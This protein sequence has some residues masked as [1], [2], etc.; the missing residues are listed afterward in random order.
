M[1][2]SFSTP[3]TVD[4]CEPN[5]KHSKYVAEPFNTLSSIPLILLGAHQIYQAVS[6]KLG[7]RFIAMGISILFVGLGSFLFHLTLLFMG[8]LAD[9]FAMVCAGIC[10][11]IS[12]HFQDD[13]SIQ[14]R[15]FILS[16]GILYCLFF[17]ITYLLFKE[18]YLFFIASFVFLVATTFISAWRSVRIVPDALGGDL[19]CNL[20]Y[21]ILIASTMAALFW[22]PDSVWCEFTQPYQLHALWHMV[23]LIPPFLMFT[24]IASRLYAD[25]FRAKTGQAVNIA[26][27]KILSLQETAALV[28]VDD[29]DPCNIVDGHSASIGAV[30][31][32]ILIPR[33][34]WSLHGHVPL[35][36]FKG[37]FE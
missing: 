13:Q 35:F 9:E 3:S 24:I 21:C 26:T 23:G 6:L 34:D 19:L 28:L 11:F 36:A 10:Y 2:F 30:S 32:E 4:F 20:F 12:F 18:W 15:I 16:F 17:L 33:I 8:Q 37:R 31:T 27:G 22:L 7:R 14:Y 25:R 1:N 5:F 29:C